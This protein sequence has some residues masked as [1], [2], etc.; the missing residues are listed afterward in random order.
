MSAEIIAVGTELTTGAKL[1]TNSQ[2]LSVELAAAGISVQYHTTVA[3]DLE[4][5]V[6]VL[7]AAV[8]RSDVVLITGGLGP[9]LD[10][11]TR[12]ALA[13][14]TNAPLL[15][16]QPSLDA[17]R[18]MFARRNRPMPERNVAQAMF[19]AGSEPIGN[20][21]GTAPGIYLEVARPGRP[22]CRVAA[23]PGVPGEMKPMFRDSVLP[24]IAPADSRRA[25]IRQ[26]RINC[27]GLGE[28]AAEELLGDITARGRDPEV[29]I[30]VHEATI[31]LR[32]VACAATAAEA[33]R[34]IAATKRVICERMGQYVFSQED[35]EM[36]HVVLRLLAERNATLATVE[37]GTTGLAAHQL[38]C[39]DGASNVFLGSLVVPTLAA[40]AR[41]LCH[42][43]PV[44]AG[45]APTDRAL[46]ERWAGACRAY[47]SADYGLAALAGAAETATAPP[48]VFL[49]LAGRSKTRSQE[50][51]ITGDRAVQQG[52]SA[53]SLLNLLR[54]EMLGM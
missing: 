17:I 20:P 5:N 11:L 36:E 23:M 50:L 34:K 7:R 43:L 53:K 41:L 30:T 47:F 21:N 54:L 16:H 40:G 42:D 9:T 45:D 48:A 28:S 6:A 15:P 26:A 52:R 46:A 38:T 8:E 39:D 12:D 29:G 1:D 10:D 3:D 22:F 24:R 2:W 37:C 14:L 27:F 32:I 19:P 31:T 49:A 35:D 44:L 18:A 13:A 51:N 33:E 25:V 4:A